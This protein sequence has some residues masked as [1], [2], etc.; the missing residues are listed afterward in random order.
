MIVRFGASR[1]L[2]DRQNAHALAVLVL[3]Q[4]AVDTVFLLILGLDVAADVLAVDLDGAAE[5]H[6]RP[7]LADGLL[8]CAKF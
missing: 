8:S 3:F 1:F 2:A 6:F 7:A 5:L 4:P